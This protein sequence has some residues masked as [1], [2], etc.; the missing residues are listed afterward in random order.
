MGSH[1]FCKGAGKL[2]TGSG[3]SPV[4]KPEAMSFNSLVLGVPPPSIEQEVRGEYGWGIPASC[5]PG[6]VPLSFLHGDL[7][8]G[9][10]LEETQ[11]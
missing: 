8:R 7:A 10:R 6:W 11:V 3:C 1:R 4:P 5:V 2:E 9:W